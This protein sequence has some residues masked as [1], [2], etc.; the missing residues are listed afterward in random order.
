M[1]VSICVVSAE[2]GPDRREPVHLGLGGGAGDEPRQPLAVA[3]VLGGHGVDA[4][5]ERVLGAEVA[6]EP[7]RRQIMRAEL[8]RLCLQAAD[9]R[10][11]EHAD[12]QQPDGERAEA[13]RQTHGESKVRKNCIEPV[14]PFQ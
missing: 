8:V 5:R 12:E 2:I 10:D 4:L 7:R 9:G 13:D 11:G 6:G 3:S 1:L 14:N